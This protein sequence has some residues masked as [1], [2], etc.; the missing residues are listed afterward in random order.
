[1][2]G[3]ERVRTARRKKHLGKQV[4]RAVIM[5]ADRVL[6]AA[7]VAVILAGAGMFAGAGFGIGLALWSA[8]M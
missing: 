6:D 3:I 7:A 4:L 5:T 1:M 2:S 8:W